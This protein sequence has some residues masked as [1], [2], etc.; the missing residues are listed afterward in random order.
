MA[1]V[2]AVK[3]H[4]GGRDPDALWAH[5][6]GLWR[7]PAQISSH[8]RSAGD[9]DPKSLHWV[10]RGPW[11]E[12]LASLGITL[13]VSREYEHLVIGLSASGEGPRLTYLPMPH[14]SGIAVDRDRGRVH[15]ASTRNPNEIYELAPVAG[16][17]ARTDVDIE[18]LADRPLI[19]IRTRFLPG[20]LYL[21]DLALIGGA[22]HG[23]AVG[24]NAV[25][26]LDGESGY[27]RRWWPRSV[28]R[29]GRPDIG[30][31][32][33]QLN[34]IA[35]GRTLATSYFS[36]S[37]ARP[38]ARRPGHRGF[39][40]NRHGV[41]FSGATR[42]PIAGGLTRP[43]SARLAAGRLWVDNSGYG[44]VG[45]VE[46]GVFRAVARL[47]GWTRGLC[48]RGRLAFV[49]TSRVIPR[50]RQYAPGLEAANSVAGVH[51]LDTTD[52]RVVASLVWPHGNQIFAIEAAPAR[53]TSGL[54]FPATGRRRP[55]RE[56]GLFYAFRPSG[57]R[58]VR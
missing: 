26:R 11:W 29:N 14:P 21:H 48:L 54:P 37:T 41:I 16:L 43:H 34:S 24:E 13:L 39:P 33:L 45:L 32:Y 25:V 55:A 35:A 4:G 47:P 7:D 42:E 18:P 28:E 2:A 8:W 27:V 22:L 38:S 23:T 36:A 15:V 30:R 12:C 49:G 58:R 19:P 40:V 56:R 44:E 52:G 53:M 10:V 31:N 50:F 57:A 46:D 3:R 17:L 5:H 20:S 9:V 6:H 51:V 1:G